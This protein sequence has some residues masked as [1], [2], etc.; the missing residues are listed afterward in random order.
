MLTDFRHQDPQNFQRVRDVD[1]S[2]VLKRTKNIGKASGSR[3]RSRLRL[4][5][6]VRVRVRG[7]SETNNTTEPVSYLRFTFVQ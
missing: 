4:R 5:V 2:P 6:R 1:E 3:V 7:S